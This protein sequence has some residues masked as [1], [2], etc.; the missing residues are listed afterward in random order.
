MNFDNDTQFNFSLQEAISLI[1]SKKRLDGTNYAGGTSQEDGYIEWSGCSYQQSKEYLRIGDMETY[2][3]IEKLAAKYSIQGEHDTGALE[4]NHDVTG[5]YPCIATFLAGEPEHMINP[6]YTAPA[7]VINLIVQVNALSLVSTQNLNH[8]GSNIFRLV[9]ALELNGYSVGITALISQYKDDGK[10]RKTNKV[11]TRV[12]EPGEYISPAI[13]AYWIGSCAGFRRAGFALLEHLPEL[14]VSRMGYYYAGGY[15]KTLACKDTD[16]PAN[17]VYF[18]PLQGQGDNFDW[19]DYGKKK[20]A[21]KGI[22][23]N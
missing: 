9:R 14:V 23:I 17:S 19:F 11:F 13:V 1:Q 10:A 12:K 22:I 7:K 6:T 18:E 15:S 20:L 3:T 5:E 2:H 8:R 21:A 4:I 16:F